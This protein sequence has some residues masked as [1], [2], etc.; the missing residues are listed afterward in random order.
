MSKYEC[1]IFGLI[2]YS[3]DLSYYEL[4][5]EE[6]RLVCGL[7]EAF[8]NRDAHHLDFW[9]AGD[10][11]QFQ[12]ALRDFELDIVRELCDETAALLEGGL[13]GR[14]LTLDKHL[15]RVHVF[16]LHPKGWEEK[17]HHIAEPPRETGGADVDDAGGR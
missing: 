4:Y 5:A 15:S 1:E 8:E 16:Y 6:E 7:Q 17:G 9:G 12:C 2:N 13:R 14:I 3:P 11:L 10:A